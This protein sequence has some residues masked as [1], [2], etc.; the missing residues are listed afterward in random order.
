MKKQTM[1]E[2]K[3]KATVILITNVLYHYS[4]YC[5]KYKVLISR[6]TIQYFSV[7]LHPLQKQSSE[8]NL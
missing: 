4:A 7:L 1:K 6:F 2:T 8:D 3:K 5:I